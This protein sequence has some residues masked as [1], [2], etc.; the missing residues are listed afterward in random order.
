MEVCCLV[1]NDKRL[2]VPNLLGIFV[3]A[4]VTGEETHASHSLDA[5]GDPFILVAVG[6]VHKRMSVDIAAE[7]IRNKIEIPVLAYSGNHATEIVRSAE[8]SLFDLVEDLVEVSVDAVGSVVVRMAE[9]LDVLG[10]VA[11]E[12]DIV[13]ADFSGDFDLRLC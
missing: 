3:D 9:I 7:I 12:E 10:E 11:E 4:A 2:D 8:C 5:L 6:V 13:L 1:V